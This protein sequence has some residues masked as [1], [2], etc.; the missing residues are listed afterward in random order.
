MKL[1][2]RRT[3]GILMAGV[4]LVS[5][6]GSSSPSTSGS[7]SSPGS[8]GSASPGAS[9]APTAAEP[10][11]LDLWVFE[12]EDGILPAFKQGFESSHPNITLEVTLVPEDLY[13][14]KL[15]TAFAA[16]S[17]PDVALMYEARWLK[18]GAFPAP[19]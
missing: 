11:T 17:P 3:P 7:P 19:R 16:G 10:V 4:L 13:V 8:A 18:A 5:A 15:D 2:G 14:T 1:V 12:G 6:C 9:S